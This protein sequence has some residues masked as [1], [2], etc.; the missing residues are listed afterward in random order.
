MANRKR[1]APK[2]KLMQAAALRNVK[3]P[4]TYSGETER[5][6]KHVFA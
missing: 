4:A 2:A 5:N 1:N 6:L 3:P